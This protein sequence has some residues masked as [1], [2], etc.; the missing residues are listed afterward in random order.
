MF[1]HYKSRIVGRKR[2]LIERVEVPDYNINRY[3][4]ALGV[5]I[6]SISCNNECWRGNII[7]KGWQIWA[8]ID[9]PCVGWVE[10]GICW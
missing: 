1:F 3:A 8:S 2:F 4:E 5:Q 9:N 7:W 6:P 10:R